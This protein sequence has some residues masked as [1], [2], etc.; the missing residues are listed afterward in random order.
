MFFTD[1]SVEIKAYTIVF[2]VLTCQETLGSL[3]VSRRTEM[4]SYRSK[5]ILSSLQQHLDLLMH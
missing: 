5:Y 3:I 2:V 1:S 4:R